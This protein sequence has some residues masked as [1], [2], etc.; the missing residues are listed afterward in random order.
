MKL[1][2]LLTLCMVSI[3]GCQ[4]ISPT[5]IPLPGWNSLVS[6]LLLED[7]S[8]PEGWER[9]RDHP[10]GSLADP[11]INHVYR[12]WWGK[13]QGNGKA[14]QAIWRATSIADS[15]PHYDE[16]RGSQFE[17]SRPLASGTTYV[18]FEPPTAIDF[19]SKVADEFYLACGWWDWAYCEVI[20]RYRNYVVEMSLDLEAEYEGYSTR[21]LTYADIETVVEAMDAKFAEFLN[22]FP[23]DTSSP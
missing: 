21:G 17:P 9:I 23:L 11:T 2:M 19:Q 14:D 7:D 18:P 16:L 8:F 15:R 4:T 5:S 6:G 3:V 13:A 10:Q 12:S 20:A 22:A 1:K